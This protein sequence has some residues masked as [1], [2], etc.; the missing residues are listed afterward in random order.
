M[1]CVTLGGNAV[2]PQTTRGQHSTSVGEDMDV[3]NLG[4]VFVLDQELLTLAWRPQR[5]GLCYG[6]TWM[7][8]ERK[9]HSTSFG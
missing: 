6:S 9:T 8:L 5:G 3:L 7:C 2:E 4:F 1:F